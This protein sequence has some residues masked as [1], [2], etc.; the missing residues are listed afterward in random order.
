MEQPARAALLHAIAHIE[1][2]AIDLAWDLIA[3]FTQ[4]PWPRAFFDL[5]LIHI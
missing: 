1:L 2:N 5:S 3:R 4:E